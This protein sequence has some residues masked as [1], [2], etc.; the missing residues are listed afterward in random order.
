MYHDL[1]EFTRMW[2]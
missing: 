2:G 1:G